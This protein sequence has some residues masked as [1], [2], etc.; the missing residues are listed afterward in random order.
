[1]PQAVISPKMIDLLER[2]A[3]AH[4]ATL[5]SDGTPHVTPL[6]IDHD[7]NTILVDVRVD[8]VKAANMRERPAVALSIVDPRN[9]YRHLDITG[10]VVSWSEDGWRDHM[11]A[12][13]RRY[14]KT[15]YPWF[16]E[17][18][19]RQIFRIEPTNVHYE[20]GDD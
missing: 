5:R 1:M 4:L 12:L 20:S 15:D 19:R 17:G 7:G 3:L 14:M 13:A 11:N 9:P 2:D 6:W 10:K 16:F 8:R 18:E